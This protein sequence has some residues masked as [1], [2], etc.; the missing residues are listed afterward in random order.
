MTADERRVAKERIAKFEQL[1]ALRHEREIAYD[2]LLQARDAVLVAEEAYRAV[3]TQLDAIN[4][5]WTD[6]A[7]KGIK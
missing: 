5:E 7:Q 3:C 6:A 2:R 1:D 4:H